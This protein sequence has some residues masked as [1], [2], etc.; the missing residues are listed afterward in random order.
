MTEQ[1]SSNELTARL[2]KCKNIKEKDGVVWKEKF[3]RSHSIE[4]ALKL[5]D[6]D[7]VIVA[8]RIIAMRW[9]GKLMFG[10]L[11]DLNGEI[12][13]SISKNDL[14]EDEYKFIKSNY[15][16]GDF[17]GIKGII[18][19]T[20]AGE[21]TIKSK[22]ITFLSKALRPLPE[23]FHGINNIETKYRQRY[24]DII[25]N[26]ETRDTMKLRFNLLR[27]IREYLYKHNFTEVETPILQNVASG[28]AARPFV[29]HHNSLN[30]DFYLRIAPEL[31]LKQ[32]IT[33]GFDRV[34]EIAKNFRNEGMDAMHLQEF[35]MM[36]WYVAYWNF[37][38]NIDFSWKLIQEII[39]KFKGSLKITYQG[40]E[41]DFSSY[42]KIDYIKT[43]NDILAVDILSFDDTNKLKNMLLE[44]NMFQEE[45]LK[46]LYSVPAIVDYVFKKMVRVN[47]I[48][49]TIVYNYPAYMIPLA[50]RNDLDV[51][52]IDIFQLIIAG[53]EIIKAYSELVNP[54]Q[55][56]EAF[57]EQVKNKQAGD[58]ETFD[59][60]EDFLRAME[61]GMPPIS[62]LGIGI[63]R[64]MCFLADVPTLRD[65]ILFP[66]MK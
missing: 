44:K 36:E 56:R 52:K 31:F 59:V 4:E 16:I 2:Q 15:D 24:L 55:Q 14:G 50:R 5:S 19:H 58:E 21:L 38:D 13:F 47:I 35:T 66:M 64:F 37:E 43:M 62:G 60:D 57:E 9:L 6:N 28:A 32:C 63:D 12:Q 42:K 49:P 11:Y 33:A 61:H 8:G 30:T 48:N 29:T 10:K 23:K 18:Y 51:K 45:E 1:I 17:I 53:A 34:F 65:T 7:E 25:S 20:D 3:K 41:I 26:K 46:D 54:I 22:H 39:K 40:Q 27:F